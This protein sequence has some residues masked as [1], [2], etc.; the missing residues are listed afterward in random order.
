MLCALLREGGG[1]AE[2]LERGFG[3]R[4]GKGVTFLYLLWA[5]FLLAL[6]GRLFA[7]R[8]LSTGYESTSP[9]LFLLVILALVLWMG[10]RK[11]SAFV[12]A[13]EICYL[14]LALVLALVLLFS[15]LDMEAGHVLPLWISDLPGAAAATLVPV[16]A[17]GCGVYA[18]FLGGEVTPRE[19]DRRRGLRW[20]AAWCVLLTLL[21]FAVIAQLGAPLAAQLE[22]PLFEVAR[23]IAVEGAFQ[24]VEATVVALWVFSDFALLG[25]LLFALKK[26]ART[27]WGARG[28]GAA[29]AAAVGLALLG[30][31]FLFPD[32]FAAKNLSETLVPA[33]N[34]VLAFPV[35]ALALLGRGWR[36]RISCARR[37]GEGTDIEGKKKR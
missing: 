1:L 23:G 18:A 15:I 30:S 27:L 33:V 25:L 32:D 28:E 2:A 20:L 17:L 24:R 8:M 9:L 26:M 35:P 16:G 37:K 34:L 19:D 36:E 6:E 22:A 5:L 12:R 3:P 21:Q 29:P 14:A 11:L 7:G 4:L 10:R 31:L 13:V